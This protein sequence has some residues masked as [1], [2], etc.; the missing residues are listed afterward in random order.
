M[1]NDK[2]INNITLKG[3]LL[4]LAPIEVVP[5]ISIDL[6]GVEVLPIFER[7]DSP[8]CVAICSEWLD[9]FERVLGGK[10]NHLHQ[11]LRESLFKDEADFIKHCVDLFLTHG[12]FVHANESVIAI[13]N[14]SDIYAKYSTYE[15]LELMNLIKDA[16]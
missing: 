14:H 15:I 8:Q 4:I 3:S 1:K 16:Y 2:N 9:W 5:V 6:T 13:Y 7:W 10:L 11:C 12:Y